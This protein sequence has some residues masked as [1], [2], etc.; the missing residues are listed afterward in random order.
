MEKIRRILNSKY[1]YFL[2]VLVVLVSIGVSL[3]I[4]KVSIYEG[5][6]THFKGRVESLKIT[7]DKYRLELS[8]KEGLICN[9]YFKENENLKYGEI[10]LGSE[11]EIKGSLKKPVNNTVPNTFNYRD[12]LYHKGIFYTCTIESIDIVGEE[13]FLYGVKNA[14]IGRIM[15]F[16]IA[17]YLYTLIIG[18]KSLLDEETYDKYRQ[19][20]VSHLFAI[21]G[22]HIG[23]F[24]IML[25]NILKKL[26]MKDYVRY[27]IVTS[28]I[29][30]YAFLVGFTPSVVRASML[31]TFGS[32]NK[33]LKLEVS[34]IKILG[35]VG[36]IL[37]VLNPDIIFDI[38]FI[39]SFSI[40]FGLLHSRS[41]LER[42]KII[43]TSLVASLY[44]IPITALNFYEVNL[45]SILINL[46]FVP[47]VSSIVYPL[48]LLTFIFRFLEPLTKCALY[49]LEFLNTASFGIKGLV[50]IVPKMPII[51]IFLYYLILVR[52]FIRHPKLVSLLLIVF[53]LST[54]VIPLLDGEFKV[55]FIDVG[56]GDS[57]LMI[58]PH[59]KE[60]ILI[61]TGG[62]TGSSYKP[63][64]NTIT[65]LKSLGIGRIDYMVFSHGDFDHMGDAS[66]IVENFKVGKVVF[67]CGGYNDLESELL[68]VL[69][70][71][72]VEHYACIKELD[73]DNGKLYFLNA[74]EYDN[75]NDNSSVIYT[76]FN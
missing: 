52:K 15:T 36:S 3:S 37:V 70:K 73:I 27:P 16:D 31:F 21:S 26:K 42:H 35:I 5:D 63:S 10:P 40:A 61:D 33:L 19:N 57:T 24:S 53:V 48:C 25:L 76:E 51:V 47:F 39:Y 74:K 55:S 17:D 49:I 30:F 66:G 13:N 29:W 34:S 4:P 71:K 18:D 56:Q 6:E 32:V 69:D 38:G 8:S 67:N 22:M 9:Y 41:F 44:S 65:Y 7:E 60:V 75:E 46:V 64:K 1:L 62:I 28:F 68:E 50:F 12:Y 20:G 23:L 58:T 43:G 2:I 72:N 54:K 14:V 11:V 59:A 45:L